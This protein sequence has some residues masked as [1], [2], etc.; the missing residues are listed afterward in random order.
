MTAG[1]DCGP[2]FHSAETVIG[3]D[4]T[5]GELHDRLAALGAGALVE[6]LDDIVE[7]RLE[8]VA[9]DD[10]LAT[11]APKINKQDAEIDWTLPAADVA[12][13]IRAYNPFP[14][15][16]TFCRQHAGGPDRL[17]I[18]R[19][20]PIG[21]AGEPGEVLRFDRDAILVACG[22]GALQL[23]ELQ[24]PGKR[25]ASTR[26]FAGQIDLSGRRLG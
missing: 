18:W 14:G 1:L 20:T 5:A 21:G 2:V 23:E 26:E 3:D 8:A 24:L 12:R 4:E 16:F 9:Q 13:R 19:A 6:H 22:E 25:R 17:K 7:G 11:Y 10:A 15:A